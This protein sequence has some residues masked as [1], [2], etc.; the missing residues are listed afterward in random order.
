MIQD[1]FWRETKSKE[2]DAII[3]NCAGFYAEAVSGQ[4]IV[5]PGDSLKV[6]VEVINRSGEKIE[7]VN[8]TLN[9]QKVR[10][11]ETALEPNVGLKESYKIFLSLNTPY[12]S[13]YWLK[14]KFAPMMYD[15]PDRMLVG[16]P[17]ND[18][19][20]TAN[21][22]LR[23]R[24]HIMSFP[25][26]ILYKKVNP[27]FGQKYDAIQVVPDVGID[28]KRSS[29]V[30][31]AGQKTLI[32][33]KVQSSKGAFKGD[34][35]LDLPP[36]WRSEPVSVPVSF[37]FKGEVAEVSFMIEGPSFEG[38]DS[39]G[40]HAVSGGRKFDKGFYEIKYEHVPYR[41]INISNKVPISVIE[42]TEIS[43]RIG[44]IA[45]AGDL[46]YES[47][48]DGGHNIHL[49]NASDFNLNQ[50]RQFKTIVLGIRAFNVLDQSA[51]LNSLLNQYVEE[52]G[53]VVV[54]YNTSNN[55]KIKQ[56]G[57]Y[58]LTL[59]RTRVTDENAEVTIL[60]P[61][62]PVFNHPNKIT[63]DDFK[64]WVQE[65]GVYFADKYDERY[66]PLLSMNDPGENPAKGSLIMAKHGK[67]T[68][69]YTGLVFYRELPSGI[70]GA[71]RLMENILAL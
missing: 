57:P 20:L 36:G 17:E 60:D 67:G 70:P 44:Y 42:E 32:E 45:G 51:Q 64:Y 21:L 69:I 10:E 13:P 34:I 12:S 58:P 62:N 1:D 5:C 14:G 9:S 48:K 16:Q 41:I 53:N 39:I 50:F 33:C 11:K 61:E 49:I 25:M 8:L 46:V 71:Y 43:G 4:Q 22:E 23:I 6:D 30:A 35:M 15:V 24:D 40:A 29:V 56:F 26:D 19:I 52:G 27:A 65:R 37:S 18:P 59:G 28:L 68:Y 38:V 47:L 66:T 3:L 7:L 2:I 31:K 55:L 54:Q 63:S